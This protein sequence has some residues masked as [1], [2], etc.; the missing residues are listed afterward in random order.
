MVEINGS[1]G[2]GQIL[3]TSLTLSLLSGEAVTV[4]NVRGD[5][6]EPGLK[7]QHLAAVETAAAVS[8]ASVEGARLGSETVEFDPGE[9]RGGRYAATID[10]AGS[11][12]LLFDTLWPVATAIDEPLVVSATG[13]TDVTWSPPMAYYRRVKLPLLREHGLAATVGVEQR[14]FYP[15]GGGRATLRL[16]PSSLSPLCLDG[17]AGFEAS[18]YS[19]ASE[20]LG[21]SNVADRQADA[22]ESA[23]DVLGVG[24]ARRE[25]V[26][27]GADSPGSALVVELDGE[28]VR[29]G[30][31]A[32][33]EPG[34]PAEDVATDAVT[35]VERWLETR[36]AV[37]EQ[38][39]DQL[40]IPLALGGG[41]V[42]VPRVTDHAETN[43]AVVRAFGYDL[44]V[45]RSADRVL[46]RAQ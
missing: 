37:D 30:F 23:L 6:P 8:D 40:L 21:D 20:S 44:T 22:A 35:D 36:A 9:P 16:W 34:K 24:T 39:A 38:L 10:T 12:T 28:G 1:A 27:A 7:H 2:G 5:R 13:G 4:E 26:Y 14:G 29:A 18:V 3:R 31:D 19:L 43:L 41:R 11:L 45:E 25:T 33:G 17:G 42:A 32:L 46:V 15:A